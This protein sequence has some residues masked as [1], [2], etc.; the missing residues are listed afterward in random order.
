MTELLKIL[1]FG[2]FCDAN[3]KNDLQYNQTLNWALLLILQ[4]KR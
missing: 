3:T 1:N 2:W 4:Y